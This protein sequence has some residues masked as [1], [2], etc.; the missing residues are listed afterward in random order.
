MGERDWVRLPIS[1]VSVLLVWS[2]S[3][4]Y[5]DWLLHCLE[6]SVKGGSERGLLSAWLIRVF[7]LRSCGIRKNENLCPSPSVVREFPGGVHMML[8]RGRLYVVLY[9]F[10]EGWDLFSAGRA[11]SINSRR[12]FFL[13]ND[14]LESS[15]PIPHRSGLTYFLWIFFSLGG[16]LKWC[17]PLLNLSMWFIVV[18]GKPLLF[19]PPTAPPLKYPEKLNILLKFAVFI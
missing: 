7:V 9:L 6:F 15:Y 17:S 3:L 11:G 2:K 13:Q 16:E 12:V 14:G 1:A 18:G 10:E 19:L 4:V 8:L 5:G